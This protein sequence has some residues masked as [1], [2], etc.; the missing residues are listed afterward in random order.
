MPGCLQ[1]FKTQPS[2]QECQYPPSS[3]EKSFAGFCK[4][5]FN[6]A[7][8]LRKHSYLQQRPTGAAAQRGGGGQLWLI[9][10]WSLVCVVKTVVAHLVKLWSQKKVPLRF[11][12]KWIVLFVMHFRWRLCIS[13][14]NI[15]LYICCGNFV[16]LQTG[17][18]YFTV[19]GRWYGL[20]KAVQW[21]I[22]GSNGFCISITQQER[23]LIASGWGRKNKTFGRKLCEFSFFFSPPH[24]EIH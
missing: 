18:V 24:C 7:S 20:F 4:I 3:F 17:P 22:R 19:C 6:K 15:S 21:K 12:R 10:R 14:Q 2:R 13:L 5:L 16:L 1:V 9:S 11:Y 8:R 23:A